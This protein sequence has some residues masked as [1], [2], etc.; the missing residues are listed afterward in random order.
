VPLVRISLMKGRP[1][2]FGD[3][4]GQIVYEAM[5]ETIDVPDGDRFQIVTEHDRAGL[6]YDSHYLGIER[7]DGIVVIQMTITEG[8]SLE[9]KK[10]LYKRIAERLNS[11]LAI[12]I[13]D[14]FVNVVEVKKENW[15]FGNG[16][17][18][19]V[20]ERNDHEHRVQ[21]GAVSPQAA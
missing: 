13:Q 7:S 14:V 5:R 21:Q 6:I 11:E 4:V 19:Y 10:A 17:A 20:I 9:K 1:A 8:R 12:R 3:K 16:V 2:G 18:Q 15:S